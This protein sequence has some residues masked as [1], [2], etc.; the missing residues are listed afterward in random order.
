MMAFST[1][2]PER[3]DLI[4]EVYRKLCALLGDI[5]EWGQVIIVNV[6]TRYARTQFTDPNIN[7]SFFIDYKT[8]SLNYYI[9]NMIVKRRSKP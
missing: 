6:L 3:I 4:H 8:N 2:C 5:D 1:V 7:V 9:V